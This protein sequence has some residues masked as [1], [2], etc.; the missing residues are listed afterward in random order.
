MLPKD[1][2]SCKIQGSLAQNSVRWSAF[3]DQTTEEWLKTIDEGLAGA[4]LRAKHMLEWNAEWEEF[5]QW[6][7]KEFGNQA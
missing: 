7:V 6:I 5:C 3:E 2:I 4:G 1:E